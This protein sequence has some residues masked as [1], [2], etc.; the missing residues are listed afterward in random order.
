MMLDHLDSVQSIL[1]STSPGIVMFEPGFLLA[2][3]SPGAIMFDLGFMQV[4]WYGFLIALAVVL[5]T[6]I[7]QRLAKRRRVDPDL[8]LDLVTWLIIGAIPCARFYYV[9]FSWEKFQGQPWQQILA[10]WEGGIA[11]HGAIIGGAIAAILF[12][13]KRQVS[14]W[15]LADLVAPSLILGQAVGRWGNFF[16]SEAFGAPTELPWKLFI[17]GDRRPEDYANQAYFHPTFLYES[18][19]NLGVFA[20]LLTV[21]Y[22]FPTAKRGTLAMI[23]LIAYSLGRFWIEGLRTDSLMLTD[24]LRIAQII[25]LVAISGGILGLWWLYG[26]DRNLPDTPAFNPLDNHS[27]SSS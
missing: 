27:E 19:W 14:F 26:R 12:A 17:P 24:N 16:N 1:S 2:F 22:R 23:Y 18:I 5:G 11:I 3:A 13:R 7:S 8:M 25:S 4:R 6:I 21:F 9:A 15:Q 20:I 10:I